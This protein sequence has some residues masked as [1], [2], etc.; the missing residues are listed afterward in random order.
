MGIYIGYII[1]VMIQSLIINTFYHEKNVLVT[2]EH[3]E[4]T[5]RKK[6]KKFLLLA[7]V[8]MIF[9]AGLRG[10]TVGADTEVYL[11]ALEY[12]RGLPKDTILIAGLVY[13]FDFEWAYFGL[14]KICAW[15]NINNTIFLF[16]IAVISYVPIFRYININSNHPLC[17]I[18]IYCS[19]GH[20]AYSLGIFRQMIAVNIILYAQK[21][22]KEKNLI[23]YILSIILAMGFHTT[24]II[25]IPLYF[26]ARIDLRKHFYKMFLAE[27]VILL[28]GREIILVIVQIFPMYAGYISSIYDI[29]GDGF[30]NLIMLNMVYIVYYYTKRKKISLELNEKMFF[31]QIG[32]AILL[33]ALATHMAIFGR[34]VI[35]YS[36]CLI[37]VIPASIDIL[38]K[39]KNRQIVLVSVMFVL[40]VLFVYR[41]YG[42]EYIC[43][44]GFFWD[45][46]SY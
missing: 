34:I 21:Y 2:L 37:L 32:I 11:K 22:I 4:Y 31:S 23:K 40:F 6:R 46:S 27:L 9:L 15:L 3:Q 14:T 12:Y 25:M 24:A 35:Y 39:G 30:L 10:Y 38:F 8:E 44:Y 7:C 17:S 41:T 42:N 1:L 5:S 43:P 28:L 26:L 29:A 16:L 19:F 13:P 36:F 18:L 20:F 45:Y 33:Q